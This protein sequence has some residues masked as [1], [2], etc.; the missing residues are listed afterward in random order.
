MKISKFKQFIFNILKINFIP[1]WKVNEYKKYEDK[2]AI[3]NFYRPYMDEEYSV[4]GKITYSN[5]LKYFFV[6]Y[7]YSI[8]DNNVIAQQ[9]GIS[10]KHD[11]IES[12]REASLYEKYIWSSNSRKFLNDYLKHKKELFGE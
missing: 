2:I 3:I 5:E 12:I 8:K 10:V 6:E 11:Y 9:L 1:K 4:I 7:P